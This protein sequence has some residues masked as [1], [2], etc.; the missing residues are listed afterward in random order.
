MNKFKPR[1]AYFN[2]FFTASRGLRIEYNT[3]YSTELKTTATHLT[4]YA[5]DV[6][7][8]CDHLE[9]QM[10]HSTV[11]RPTICLCLVVRMFKYFHNARRHAHAMR[12]LAGVLYS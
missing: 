7:N 2:T 9:V 4:S 10:P 11:R 1:L 3:G 12:T 5:L 8:T 6:K